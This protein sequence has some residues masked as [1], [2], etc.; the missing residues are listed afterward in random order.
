MEVILETSLFSERDT[1][2][3]LGFSLLQGKVLFPYYKNSDLYM[4]YERS[5]VDGMEYDRE[6]FKV[7]LDDAMADFYNAKCVDNNYSVKEDEY[8]IAIRFGEFDFHV[9]CN[10]EGE[11]YTNMNRT[12]DSFGNIGEE[13]PDYDW[14]HY[15]NTYDCDLYYYAVPKPNKCRVVIRGRVRESSFEECVRMIKN[16]SAKY[17]MV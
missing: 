16:N 5:R 13:L 7:D 1:A 10:L 9:V 6:S 14:H 12:G 3:C 2:N 11:W 8:L 15:G 17:E 4:F